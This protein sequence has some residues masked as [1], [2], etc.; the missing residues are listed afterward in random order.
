MTQVTAY[1]PMMLSSVSVVGG[2]GGQGCIGLAQYKKHD[3]NFYND[4]FQ[5]GDSILCVTWR[6]PAIQINTMY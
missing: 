3:I 2:Y 1:E 5:D 6:F 4:I